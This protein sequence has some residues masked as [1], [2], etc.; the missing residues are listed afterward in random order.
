MSKTTKIALSKITNKSINV[1]GT[2]IASA[3]K[4]TAKIVIEL[5]VILKEAWT[6]EIEMR[7]LY[8]AQAFDDVRRR[9]KQV[10]GAWIRKPE[11]NQDGTYGK[12]WARG[13]IFAYVDS[14]MKQIESFVRYSMRDDSIK[15]PKDHT[16]F[17]KAVKEMNSTKQDQ[18]R[19][20]AITKLLKEVP[21][22]TR[23]Q[24]I[25][26][27]DASESTAKSTVDRLAEYPAFA[28]SVSKALDFIEASD[29]KG[30]ASADLALSLD[31]LIGKALA[32]QAKIAKANG[33]RDQRPT[34]IPQD[35][36]ILERF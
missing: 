8:T 25:E 19:E 15:C 20:K 35:A 16:A 33:K 32:Q 17:R 6:E 14:I 34:E 23:N 5:F 28:E 24:A 11:P 12:Q 1:I 29:N 3:Y 2:L 4:S 9:M 31:T 7:G 26:I 18:A 13:S 36:E 21:D 30:K 22:C 27:L 10:N